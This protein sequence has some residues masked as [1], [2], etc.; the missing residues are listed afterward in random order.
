MSFKRIANTMGLK[1]A[2]EAGFKFWGVVKRFSLKKTKAIAFKVILEGGDTAWLYFST[3]KPE[4]Y[5]TNGIMKFHCKYSIIT[6]PR[7]PL[8]EGDISTIVNQL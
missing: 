1:I 7:Q 5:Y 8:C 2:H 3:Q 6:Q 4:F